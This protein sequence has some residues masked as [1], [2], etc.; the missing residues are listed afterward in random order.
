M[1]ANQPD[2]GRPQWRGETADGKILLIYAEQGFGDTLQ[3]CRYGELAAARGLRVIMRVPKPLVR[4]LRS[5]S[6]VAQ[7][8]AEDEDLPAFDLQCPMLSMPLALAT[9][10]ATIPSRIPYLA[11][12]EA[13][14]A[15]WQSRLAG[16]APGPRIGLVWAGSARNT[17]A[18]AAVD[19]RRSIAPDRL[20]PLLDLQGLHFF[21][22]QK[23]GPAGSPPLPLID[24]MTEMQDF[25]DTAALVANLDLIISVDTAAAHLAAALGKPV[26]LLNRFDSCW[27]WLTDRRDSP[28]Y[29]TLRL[30]SQPRPGDWDAVIAELVRDLRAWGDAASSLGAATI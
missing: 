10:P 26:W 19:R 22:L 29:P 23:D 14:V 7:V 9:T 21:S 2:L 18:L 24:F 17:P 6:G 11:A 5:L 16:S 28:W 20:A 4:L 3:F 27:R 12:E 30:Y 25:A 13:A 1:M 8:I 15:A